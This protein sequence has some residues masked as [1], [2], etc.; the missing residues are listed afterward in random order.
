MNKK[1]VHQIVRKLKCSGKKRKEIKLQLLSEMEEERNKGVSAEEIVNRMGTPKEIAEEFNQ[2][3]SEAEKKRYKRE[4]RA[5]IAG[6]ILICLLLFMIVLYW[7]L[8]KQIWLENSQVFDEKQALEQAKHVVALFDEKEYD[9]LKKISDETMKEHIN[10]T[11]MEASKT[12]LGKEWGEQI[13]IG[14]SYAVEITQMGKKSALIQMHVNYENISVLYTI[15]FN[16]KMEL[17]GFYM[18]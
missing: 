18:K 4:K 6:I 17:Q 2:N 12:L 7:V 11:E 3:F 10:E 5:K 1:Y 15:S 8:P 14:K 13:S 9:E 16:E